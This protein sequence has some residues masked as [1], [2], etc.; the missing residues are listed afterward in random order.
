MTFEREFLKL[1]SVWFHC[2]WQVMGNHGTD[3]YG[4]IAFRG[5]HDHDSLVF[6]LLGDHDYAAEMRLIC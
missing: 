3:R 4:R 2:R 5:A 6:A 1:A